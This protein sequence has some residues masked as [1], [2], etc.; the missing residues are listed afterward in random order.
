VAELVDVLRVDAHR[1][2]ALILLVE[3]LL[4]CGEMARART[5]LARA[6]QSGADRE[7][8]DELEVR[9]MSPDTL[10][11]TTVPIPP[12]IVPQ[13]MKAQAE[14]SGRPPSRRLELAGMMFQDD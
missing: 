5:I 11:Q 1:P 9:M 8:L 7:R 13:A 12:S 3:G 14:L 6:R 4:G 2:D 10:D